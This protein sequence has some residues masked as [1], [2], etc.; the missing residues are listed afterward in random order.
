MNID[1]LVQMVND[2]ANYFAAEPDP[3]VGAE[4]V[5]EH[6]KRFWAPPMRRQILAHLDA[7]GEGLGALAA[8][9]VRRL[10]QLD[11]VLTT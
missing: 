11:R 7:G 6:L 9:G 3:V 10:A 5:A 1:R 4:G 8:A 2:I